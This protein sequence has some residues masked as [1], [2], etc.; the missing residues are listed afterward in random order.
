PE[1]STLIT[2]LGS[3]DLLKVL[4][5]GVGEDGGDYLHWDKLRHKKPPEGL[6]HKEWWLALKWGRQQLARDLPLRDSAGQPFQYGT[7]DLV[8]RLL[9]YVDQRC[10]GSIAMP[11]VVTADEQAR[12]HYLVN[13]LME[14]AIRSS[15]L[16]GATTSRRVA[17]D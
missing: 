8:L 6:T 13:S 12:Q 5:S 10:S 15:Q 2:N 4:R 1:F 7:P 14:E 3:D 9:H 17:K 16:E 11:E